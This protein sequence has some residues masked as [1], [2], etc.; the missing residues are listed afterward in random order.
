MA[1]DEVFQEHVTVDLTGC[2]YVME[3]WERIKVGI[4]LASKLYNNG[5]WITLE[6]YFGISSSY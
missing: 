3:F 4:E 1:E 6:E 2:K 5:D